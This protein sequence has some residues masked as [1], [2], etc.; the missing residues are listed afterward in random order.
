MKA[1]SIIQAPGGYTLTR[2]GVQRWF[3]RRYPAQQCHAT[4]TGDNDHTAHLSGGRVAAGA[5]LAG[6]AGAIIGAMAR[7]DTGTEIFTVTTPA[8]T[9]TH[10]VSGRDYTAAR[11]FVVAL[12]RERARH[13][14]PTA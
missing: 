14:A 4:I 13:T 9:T 12:E 10:E 5:V 11:Q 8:G 3:G 6:P 2:R 1:L 7:R